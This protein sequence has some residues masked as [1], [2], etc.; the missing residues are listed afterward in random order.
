MELSIEQ[1]HS[2]ADMIAAI[3]R[4]EADG[5]VIMPGN[6][7]IND[8]SMNPLGSIQHVDGDIFVFVPHVTNV[9]DK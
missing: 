1:L 7:P 2:V 6:I 3:Q 9:T 4:I 8:T 5:A